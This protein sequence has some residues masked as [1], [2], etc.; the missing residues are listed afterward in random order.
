MPK[1]PIVSRIIEINN[2]SRTQSIETDYDKEST[3][4]EKLKK[5]AEEVSRM[6]TDGLRCAKL[7]QH[8]TVNFIETNKRKREKKIE[9][10]N[11]WLDDMDARRF[12][13]LK[14]LGE[15]KEKMDEHLAMLEYYRDHCL[16]LALK[17][18][19]SEISVEVRALDKRLRELEETHGSR[20]LREFSVRQDLLEDKEIDGGRLRDTAESVEDYDASAT[21]SFSDTSP[22]DYDFYTDAEEYSVGDI[23][24]DS[25]SH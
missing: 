22:L 16:S 11:L 1:N 5:N 23:S 12:R 14:V 4:R 19:A 17:G 3:E 2:T 24:F 25:Y 9:K 18:S 7:R 21:P 10:L 8:A 20:I 13:N 6:I 15:E